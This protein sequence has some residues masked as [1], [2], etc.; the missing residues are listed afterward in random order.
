MLT[1]IF[2]KDFVLVK[3]LD[4]ELSSGL[5]VLTGETGAGKSIL[6]DAVELALGARGNPKL[7]RQD[8][9]QCDISLTFDVT[10]TPAAI[11]WLTEQDLIDEDHCILRRILK[12]DGKSRAYI[13]GQPVTVQQLKNL[14]SLLLNIHGQHEHQLLLKREHQLAALDA[15]AGHHALV[16][17][18][19]QAYTQWHDIHKQLT[20]LQNNHQQDTQRLEFLRFQLQE[21]KQLNLQADELDNL[22]QEHK[23]L[24]NADHVSQTLNTIL[25]HLS[26][27]EQHTIEQR[28]HAAITDLTA[29]QNIMPELTNATEL[30]NNGLI[31]VQEAIAELKHHTTIEYDPQRLQTIEQRLSS[32]YELARKHKVN[33]AELPNLQQQ[34]TEEYQQLDNSDEH[35]KELEEHRHQLQDKYLQAAKQLSA[36]RQQAAKKLATLITQTLTQLGMAGAQLTIQ[37]T[38]N[39]EDA[40]AAYGLEKVEFLVSTNPGQPLQALAKVAS[41]GELSR[42]S[43]AI[44]AITAAHYTTP[45]LIFDEVDTGIGGN[46]AAIVG[47]LLQTLGKSTQVFCVTHLAQVAACANHHLYVTKQQSAHSTHTTIQN[48]TEKDKVN[49]IARMLSGLKLTKQTIAH[50]KEMLATTA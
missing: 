38:T 34:L 37:M 31:Q 11:T 25:N 9:T 13:N 4:L 36:S 20:N 47:K 48:L 8:C 40:F 10:K 5:T 39:P 41:G 50:A 30:L 15:Y 45:T 26:E 43:L 42:I 23:Q 1:H 28:L 44:Q 21:F 24:A 32:I 3:T 49:E 6:I 16:N 12:K 17:K 27:D 2:I 35:I 7:I 29:L 14:S 18:V 19:R 22:E 33:S 46:V